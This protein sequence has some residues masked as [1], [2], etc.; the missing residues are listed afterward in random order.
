[1]SRNKDLSLSYRCVYLARHTALSRRLCVEYRSRLNVLCRRRSRSGLWLWYR[2]WLWYRLWLWC[3]LWLWYRLYCR[4]LRLNG[5][6]RRNYLKLRI[7]LRLVRYRLAVRTVLANDSV[8]RNGA[9]GRRKIV[10]FYSRVL[11]A[12]KAYHFA[13]CNIIVFFAVLDSDLELRCRLAPLRQI[14]LWNVNVREYLVNVHLC[15]LKYLHCGSALH[16]ASYHFLD[17][18]QNDIAE[19]GIE[20]SQRRH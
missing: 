18:K 7:F 13:R 16:R 19:C 10:A 12:L 8:S 14:S 4:R 9:C 3:R 6:W 1:M 2:F 15:D 5:S 11:V 17:R 20:R